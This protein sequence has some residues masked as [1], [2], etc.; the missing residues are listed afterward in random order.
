[1][2]FSDLIYDVGMNN[3][4]DTAYY[5]HCGYR[6]VAVEADPAFVG[7]C[8][9]RFQNAVLSG[10]LKILNC[11]VGPTPGRAKFW[12]CLD[13]PEWNSFRK[14]GASRRGCRV[15]EIEVT[16]RSFRSILEEHGTPHYLKVD[17]EGYDIY[18]LREL[19]H[20]DLPTYLSIELENMNEFQTV[21]D[22]GYDR[23]KLILQRRHRALRDETRTFAWRINRRA[24]SRPWASHVA[25]KAS[26]VKHRVEKSVQRVARGLKL[27]DAPD[28]TFPH[29]SSGPFGDDAP[30]SWLSFEDA[31]FTWLYYSRTYPGKGWCDLHA[32]RS[33]TS[34]CNR[35]TA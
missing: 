26:S 27:A 18:C 11:A 22:L 14:E 4:D 29:G 16:V 3:G 24:A 28:W 10:R 15:Q 35:L 34:V 17:I 2:P 8:E 12:R 33:S 32:T 6:V 20:S 7:I 30:G 5:L 13:R 25:A 9:L 31:C 23:F 19:D 21:R 1:M